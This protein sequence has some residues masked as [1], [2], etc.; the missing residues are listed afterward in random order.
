[1]AQTILD[2][3]DGAQAYGDTI[4]YRDQF[5][6]LTFEQLRLYA[7]RA[8][9]LL[10]RITE[11][12]R[13]V[14]VLSGRNVFVPALYLGVASAGCFYVP[15]SDDLPIF[16][17]RLILDTV[18]P[19]ALVLGRDCRVSV[20]ELG[21]EGPVVY[22][23]D[24]GNAPVDE[25]EL[26]R[27]RSALTDLD[28]LYVLF[29]SGSSG[30]PKGVVTPHRAVMDYLETFAR[31]FGIKGDDVFGSQA[32]LDYVAAIRD[33]YLPLVTGARTALIP[34]TLFSLP[35][36]LFAYCNEQRITTLC[37]VTAALSL[38]V[39]MDVFSVVKLETVNK[40]FFTGAV[41]PAK[42]LR[43]WQDNL[44]SALFV[45]HYGP[46]EIT[47]SCTY[48]VV[49]H[50]LSAEEGIP[51]GVPFANR[52]ILI[53]DKQH[54][55]VPVGQ[56]GEICVMGACLALGYYLDPEKTAAAFVPAPPGY[57]GTMYKTGDLGRLD[58]RGVLH[59]HGRRDFQ[60]KHMGHRVELGEIEAAGLE[61]DVV[62]Q[63][64]CLYENNQL[65]FFY[66]GTADAR[67][68]AVHFRSRLPGYMIPKK[69][70]ALPALPVTFSGKPDLGALRAMT[71]VTV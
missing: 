9:S 51:I 35:A 13:P 37:W 47:A 24:I 40:V 17:L 65:W 49:D 50:P 43:I 31:T 12:G 26:S 45:N 63:C 3:L 25:E 48:H 57:H 58:A 52:R 69:L 68:L 11:S 7:R 61:L 4:A 38:C 67:T 34:K 54:E 42:D 2:A 62:R 5:D 46:T 16:R 32:P 71:A 19:A 53:V 20:A 33:L 28:P 23:A 66:V 14:V 56:I 1:M 10:C 30:V 60:I 36:K 22:F 8:G 41:M 21:Y 59:F 64:C 39:G 6:T 27:R 29:T 55:P 15:L 44:P 18:K 70:I